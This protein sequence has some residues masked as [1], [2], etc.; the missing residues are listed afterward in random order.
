[1][2]YVRFN[3]QFYKLSLH[4]QIMESLKYCLRY[5]EEVATS[6]ASP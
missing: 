6:V 2:S 5:T 1:M 3:I 4:L